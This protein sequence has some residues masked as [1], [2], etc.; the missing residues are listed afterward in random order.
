MKP[1]RGRQDEQLSVN[2]AGHAPGGIAKVEFF[3]SCHCDGL[4]RQTS[5][6]QR[7]SQNLDQ[8]INGQRPDGLFPEAHGRQKREGVQRVA[9]MI[10][11]VIAPPVHHAGLDD[12]VVEA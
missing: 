3:G 6:N 7:S 9:E 10:Q 1:H 5:V 2:H 4:P 11:H 8:V 12:G